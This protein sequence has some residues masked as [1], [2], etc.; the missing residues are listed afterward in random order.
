[1]ALA[2]TVYKWVD[3]NGVTH[4][5]DQPHENAEKV[6]VAAP[7]TY[8]APQ[9]KNTAATAAQSAQPSTPAPSTYQQCSV[10]SPAASQNFPNTDTVTAVTV[11]SPAPHDGDKAA[12]FVDG[13]MQPN[14]PVTGGSY[15]ISPVTRGEHSLMLVVE[16][17]GGRILCQSQNVTFSVT[18]PSVLNPANPNFKH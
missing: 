13:M 9:A 18:Q 12:L 14:F 3:E 4:Y 2:A 7:Q 1:M 16:D 10:V 15:T 6:H 11:I 17:S 8:S 5:S